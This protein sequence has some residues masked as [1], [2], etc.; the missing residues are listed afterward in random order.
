MFPKSK[1]PMVKSITLQRRLTMFPPTHMYSSGL[2]DAPRHLPVTHLTLVGQEVRDANPTR[3]PPSTANL[4]LLPFALRP[5]CY[6]PVVCSGPRNLRVQSGAPGA[7]DIPPIP[8]VR[9]L[10][11]SVAHLRYPLYSICAH[12]RWGHPLW[13]LNWSWLRQ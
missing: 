13:Q 7:P 3:S 2:F 11:T 1:E 9:T 6:D 10:Y 5:S 12:C 4:I 8:A